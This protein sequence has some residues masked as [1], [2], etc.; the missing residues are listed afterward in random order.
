[1]Y[2]GDGHA[3]TFTPEEARQSLQ[4][5]GARHGP[6]IQT[7]VIAAT[8]WPDGSPIPAAD[9]RYIGQVTLFDIDTAH[10]SARLR[11]GLFDRRFWARGCGREAIHRVLRDAFE[12]RQLHRVGLRVAAYN[13]RAIRSYRACGFVEEGRER[14]AIWL[15]GRWWDD[16][17]MGVL[18]ADVSGR[19]A[20]A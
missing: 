9:G 14:E 18:A 12:D 20:R 8:V 1:M 7:W 13:E 3:K 17:V 19:E 6:T 11:I 4:A 10:R 15:D 5:L 16:V 2:G